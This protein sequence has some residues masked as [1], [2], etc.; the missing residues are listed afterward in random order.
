MLSDFA[1]FLVGGGPNETVSNLL[2]RWL[3]GRRSRARKVRARR[4]RR[5]KAQLQSRRSTN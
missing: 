1:S 3:T 5:R 2:E 4:E